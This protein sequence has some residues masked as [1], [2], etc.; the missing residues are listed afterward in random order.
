MLKWRFV[1]LLSNVVKINDLKLL[2]W[3]KNIVIRFVLTKTLHFVRT[4]DNDSSNI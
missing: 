3:T 1:N 2:A 4:V